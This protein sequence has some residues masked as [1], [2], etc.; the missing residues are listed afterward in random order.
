MG[1]IKNKRALTIVIVILLLAVLVSLPHIIKSGYWLGIVETAIFWGLFAMSMDL[2]IGYC[3]LL[4]LGHGAF[5]GVAAYTIG[6][7]ITKTGYGTIPAI[8]FSIL[9]STGMALLFGLLSSHLKGLIFLMVS[10][11]ISQ[12][13][14]GIAM[15]MTSLTNGDNGL[16]G[17]PKP[18]FG[19]ETLSVSGFYYFI[20]IITIV[21]A[22]LLLLI[23]KSPYGLALKGLKQSESRMRVLGYNV[24]LYKVLVNT[25]SGIFAGTAGMMYAFYSGFVGIR[26]VSVVTSAQGLIMVLAGGAGT[27]VGPIIGAAA[28][29]FAQNLMSSITGRWSMVLGLIY[30]AVV[31]LLPN[32]I[33][34]LL[35]RKEKTCSPLTALKK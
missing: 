10:I 14:W 29:I 11:A 34:G 13:I 18:V 30:I 21:C 28:I 31:L 16:T 33:I 7:V 20:L 5:F 2:L 15:Q 23:T 22:L 8:V 17:I 35:W 26:D 12:V 27:L 24:W 4:T 3:G 19:G 1:S 25:I 6:I 32:G 9:V